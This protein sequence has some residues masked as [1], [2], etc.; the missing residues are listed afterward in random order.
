MRRR[1]PGV[2]QGGGYAAERRCPGLH[3]REG[4]IAAALPIDA[5]TP[6]LRFVYDRRAESDDTAIDDAEID[7]AEWV[8][9]VFDEV[10]G[11]MPP[12]PWQAADIDLVIGALD[13]LADALTPCPVPDA[14]PA[15]ESLASIAG[16]WTL[17]AQA[18]PDDLEPW[19]AR[20]L[21]ALAS[22]GAASLDRTDGDTMVHFDVRA[23]NLLI[24]PDRR[25]VV[26]D[27][28]HAFVGARWLDVA[29]FAINIAYYGGDP[30]AALAR[31]RVFRAAPPEH[32]TGFLAAVCGMF[33]E[34]SRQPPPPGL[35]TVRAFQRAQE[36]AMIPW[37][38]SRTGWE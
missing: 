37:L 22:I 34:R 29:G 6:R 13:D 26:V 3:R 9:L 10:D 14:A 16:S 36:L 38:A 8:A 33:A 28:P 5:P 32:V 35:P 17:L 25:V 31:S 2:L 15:R 27:W 30:E 12:T 23:D 4:Q 19:E 11:T 24:T 20:H 7:G 21:D 1:H 18:P